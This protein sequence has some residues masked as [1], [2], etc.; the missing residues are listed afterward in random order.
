[1]GRIARRWPPGDAH[2]LSWPFIHFSL[3][4]WLS[5]ENGLYS[6]HPVSLHRIRTWNKIDPRLKNYKQSTRFLHILLF[7]AFVCSL[8]GVLWSNPGDPKFTSGKNLQK[9]GDI[10]FIL[11]IFA[12]LAVVVYLLISSVNSAQRRDPI[13]VQILIVMPILL[14]RSSFAAV[15]AFMSGEPNVWL[16]LGLLQIPDLVSDTIYTGYG[17]ALLKPAQRKDLIKEQRVDGNVTLSRRHEIWKRIVDRIRRPE[18]AMDEVK[19]DNL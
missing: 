18:E 7:V 5:F 17:L 14:I 11:A 12:I 15:Q 4:L 10:I 13:L 1:M 6:N 19:D 8:L 16:N 9:V 2:S 3:Q